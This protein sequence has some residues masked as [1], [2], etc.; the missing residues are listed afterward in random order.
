MPDKRS[1]ERQ[2]VCSAPECQKTRSA[3]YLEKWRTENPEY[4]KGRYSNLQEWLGKNEGYLKEYREKHPE[5]CE[6]NKLAQ[7]ERNHYRNRQIKNPGQ[8]IKQSPKRL[9]SRTNTQCKCD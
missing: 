9:E 1:G 7:R 6:R 5:Y 3:V 2:S 8:S 4:F